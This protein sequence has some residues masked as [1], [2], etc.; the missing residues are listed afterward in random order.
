MDRALD[1]R[2]AHGRS[3]PM[4]W[5]DRPLRRGTPSGTVR[6]CTFDADSSGWG[7][8]LILAGAVPLAVRAGYSRRGPGRPAVEPVAADPDR[9]RRRA[10]PAP[11]ASRHSSAA[12]SWRR[13][14]GLMVGGLLS[15]GVDRVRRGQLR[16][17][18]A[19]PSRSR[20]A[21]ATFGATGSIDVQL[22]CG[23]L[24]VATAAGDGW[25]R[26]GP[27]RQGRRPDDHERLGRERHRASGPTTRADRSGLRRSRHVAGDPAADPA[28]RPRRP[29]ER[30]ERD[31]RPRGRD[32]RTASISR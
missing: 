18:R 11:D 4:R 1:A 9:D 16:R 28:P 3:A 29:A 2:L 17:E 27:G 12:S 22:D 20:R 5:H 10:H 6:A 23:T 25:Q 26:R 8:F 24:T 32:P 31:H 21:T 19:R 7:V 14:S 15:V 13:P 30:R